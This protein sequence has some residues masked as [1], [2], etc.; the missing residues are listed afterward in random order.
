MPHFNSH[1]TLLTLLVTL[2]FSATSYADWKNLDGSE[3]TTK[4]I[5]EAKQKCQVDEKLEKLTNM[6]KNSSLP[7]STSSF[8][9]A[10]AK[11]KLSSDYDSAK[12][13]THDEINTCM[14]NAGLEQK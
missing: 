8:S 3:A 4:A 1:K 6:A 13:A 11:K 2:A 12:K 10:D 9:F 5:N 14:K 7:K